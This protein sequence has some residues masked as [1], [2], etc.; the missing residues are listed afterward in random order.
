MTTPFG[1]RR[2]LV[3]VTEGRRDLSERLAALG[4]DV[5]EAECIVIAPPIDRAALESR[6]RRW[7]LGEYDWMAVTSRNAVL[8][9][10]RVA[11]AAGL[12]LDSGGTSVATVGEATTQVCRDLGLAVA[13]VPHRADARGIVAEFPD[14]TGEVLIPRGNLAAP[15]LERGV[16]SKGWTVDVVEAYRTV[17]GPGLTPQ[18]RKQLVEGSIDAVLLTSTSVADRISRDLAGA[19]I[20]SR[21]AVVAIGRTTAAGARALGLVPTVVAERPSHDGILE[22]LAVAFKEQS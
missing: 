10:D 17:D 8:A 4:C 19:P 14:G 13:L 16:A 12:R 21:T 6:V 1:G 5:V 15:V 3:P 7:A 2:L 9:M 20:P 22:A 18:A 11:C